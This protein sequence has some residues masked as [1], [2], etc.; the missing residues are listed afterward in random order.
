VAP[1]PGGAS[2]QLQV[3]L[4]APLWGPEGDGGRSKVTI[5]ELAG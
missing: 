4:A 5:V 3:R 2:L 1:L